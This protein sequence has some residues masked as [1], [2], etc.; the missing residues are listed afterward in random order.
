MGIRNVH[1]IVENEVHSFW[2]SKILLIISHAGLDNEFLIGY[3][4]EI[5]MLIISHN[6]IQSNKKE[7][8]AW[9]ELSSTLS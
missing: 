5:Y 1:K 7:L 6:I 2:T 3:F 4:F 9:C 8:N